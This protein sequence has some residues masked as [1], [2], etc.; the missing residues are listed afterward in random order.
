MTNCARVSTRIDPAILDA[1][2]AN[3]KKMGLT[4]DDLVRMVMT[5]AAHD[6]LNPMD[7]MQPSETTLAAMRELE[8]GAGKSCDSVD[9]LMAELNSDG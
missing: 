6:K 1:A 4:I 7:F 3:L 9:E 5:H 2:A 8:A